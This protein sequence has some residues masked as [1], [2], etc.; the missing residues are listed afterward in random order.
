MTKHKYSFVYIFLVIALLI[1][2]GYSYYQY[3]L[4][5]LDGDLVPIVAPSEGYTRVLS[6]PFGWPACINNEIYPAT[7]RFTA[8]ATLSGYFKFMPAFLQNFVSPIDSIFVSAALAKIC[9]HICI[10]LLLGWFISGLFQFRWQDCLLGTALVSPFL[11]T[12]GPFEEYMSI[13]DYSITYTFFYAL[14]FVCILL[15]LIPFYKTVLS[16]AYKFPFWLKPISI[17]FVVLLA[18]FGALPAPILTIVVTIAFLYFF[19]NYFPSSS[20]A[21]I[22]TKSFDSIKKINFQLLLFLTFTLCICLYSIYVGTKN[23]ENTWTP[24]P[25]WERYCRLPDGIIDCFFTFKRG[26]FVLVAALFINVVILLISQKPETKL[27]FKISL[28]L[29]TFSIVYML[30]LPLG[31]YR[32]YRPLIIRRD[33]ILPVLMILYYCWG[34]SSIMLIKMFNGLGKGLYICFLLGISFFYMKLDTVPTYTNTCEKE[35]LQELASKSKESTGC[36]ALKRDCTIINWGFMDS[37]ENS[38]LIGS[39]LFYWN[40]TPREVEFYQAEETK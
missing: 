16:S 39:M 36:I 27:F 9:L 2:V 7:N 4:A 20:S 34:I 22:I 10:V 14:P 38:K 25:L 28:F 24:L 17:A 40:I 30:L 12:C 33:T 8:H 35:Y 13:I 29:T 1:D 15:L 5:R 18:F 11:Y 37:C 32:G 19:F 31:G 23:L 6:E 3:S 26:P 21:S